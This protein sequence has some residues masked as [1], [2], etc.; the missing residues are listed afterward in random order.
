MAPTGDAFTVMV[1]FGVGSGVCVC[2]AAVR[3]SQGAG[4]SSL[5]YFAAPVVEDRRDGCG[6]AEVHTWLARAKALCCMSA[7][8]D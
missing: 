1:A 8:G 2:A 7:V 6:F 3:D 5:S 4:V